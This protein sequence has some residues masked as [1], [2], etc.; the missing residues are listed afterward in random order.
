MFN[1]DYRANLGSTQCANAS[2]AACTAA[3]YFKTFNAATYPYI[4]T[5]LTALGTN[6]LTSFDVLKLSLYVVFIEFEN[7]EG[8]FMV[9][10]NHVN[11]CAG[12]SRAS[13]RW[14]PPAAPR[15]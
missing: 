1:L 5:Y 13:P 14:M 4:T 3:V 10:H 6:K 2:L 8:G 12:P 11:S 7:F 9:S 15:S